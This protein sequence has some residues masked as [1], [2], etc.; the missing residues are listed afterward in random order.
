[1]RYVDRGPQRIANWKKA[2]DLCAGLG[3]DFCALVQGGR[4]KDIVEKM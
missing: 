3:E 1:M 2:V 4:I